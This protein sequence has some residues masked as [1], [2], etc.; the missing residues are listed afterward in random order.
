MKSFIAFILALFGLDAPQPAPATSSS[1]VSTPPT[2]PQTVRPVATT[3][4]VATNGMPQLPSNRVLTAAEVLA[5][6][7]YICKTYFPLVD[8]YMLLAMAKIES[9]FNPT[10]FRSEPRLNDASRGLVQIL[11]RTAQDIY[12]RLKA[13]ALGEPTAEKLNAPIYSLYMAAAYVNW[14]RTY[15]G[16]GRSEE[17]IVRAYNGGPGW[18]NTA[19]AKSMTLNHWNKYRKARGI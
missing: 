6:A 12:T 14:L 8:P 10:A 7:R 5:G 11:M 13:R 15:G 2:P 4:P 9:N 18:E 16:K 17:W 19:N 1:V 3:P